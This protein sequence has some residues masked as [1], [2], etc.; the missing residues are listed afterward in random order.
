M[1][2]DCLFVQFDQV[3]IPSALH[4]RATIV[5]YIVLHSKLQQYPSTVPW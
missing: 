3:C 4:Y 1:K 2:H 5:L